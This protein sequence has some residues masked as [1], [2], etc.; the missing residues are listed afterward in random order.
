VPVPVPSNPFGCSVS[1]IAPS[2][3]P[4]TSNENDHVIAGPAPFANQPDQFIIDGTF[5]ITLT[6][7]PITQSAWPMPILQSDDYPVSTRNNV[8]SQEHQHLSTNRTNNALEGHHRTS[9]T[10][11]NK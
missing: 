3:F 11:K 4:S 5:P 6:A 7:F 1:L 9:D 10:N 2:I 8:I